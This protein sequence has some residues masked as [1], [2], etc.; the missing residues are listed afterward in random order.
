MRLVRSERPLRRGCTSF[1]SETDILVVAD[2]VLVEATDD[3]GLASAEL[4]EPVVHSLE[5]L[6]LHL[7][8][9]VVEV[10]VEEALKD[11]FGNMADVHGVIV[12]SFGD[13]GHSV[14][15]E[16]YQR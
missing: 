7:G 14:D 5:H 8:A 3:I 15:L 4:V 12:P 9:G 2:A 11:L 10:R 6:T 13:Q 16:R 1:A